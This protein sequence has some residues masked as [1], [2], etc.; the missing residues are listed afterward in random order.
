MQKLLNVTVY[1]TH[2]FVPGEAGGTS[3]LGKI[4]LRPVLENFRELEYHQRFRRWRVKNRFYAYDHD[5]LGFLLPRYALDQL[6]TTIEQQDCVLNITHEIDTYVPAAI[7]YDMDHKLT[8]RENQIPIIK[9]LSRTDVPIVC[10]DL[11]M[12]QGKTYCAMRAIQELKLRSLIICDGLV[13]QWYKEILLKTSLTEKDIYIIKGADSI[14]KLW[15]KKP[16]CAIYIAGI[17]TV[18]NYASHKKDP[19]TLLPSYQDFLKQFQIGIKVIDE[20]HLNFAAIVS[21]DMKSICPRNIYLSA[22]PDRS[23]KVEKE[24]FQTVFPTEFIIGGESRPKY[25]N[26]TFYRYNLEFPNL[27]NL[28]TAYGYSHAKYEEFIAENSSVRQRFIDHVLLPLIHSHYTSI[29]KDK[30]KLL[31]FAKTV[32]FC[33]MIKGYLDHRLPNLDIRTFTQQDPESN[34]EEADIIVS[35]PTSCG[36]GK[37]IKHLRTVITTC[38]IASEPLVTQMFGRLRMLPSG[39]IPEYVDMYNGKINPQHFHYTKRKKLYQML[40]LKYTE[41][42]LPS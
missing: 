10:S 36:T 18:R 23:S 28:M 20:F 5:N 12:G 35:T 22:T 41:H 37:D 39:D 1:T 24:I 34:L 38:S 42:S 17:D 33:T 15:K 19:Y 27:K 32:N 6:T 14:V 40:A 11:F 21:I 30:Q 7:S 2:I 31:I 26:C 3:L 4:D 25:V 13:V 16:Q 29:K 9:H 8:D